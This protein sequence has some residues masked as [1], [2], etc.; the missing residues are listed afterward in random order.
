MYLNELP[1]TYEYYPY[2]LP[3][4]PRPSSTPS[5]RRVFSS[6]KLFHLSTTLIHHYYYY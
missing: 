5:I 6:W 2:V 4:T 1:T 3:V